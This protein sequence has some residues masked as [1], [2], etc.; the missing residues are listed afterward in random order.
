MPKQPRTNMP[1]RDCEPWLYEILRSLSENTRAA[2][3]GLASITR[4]EVPDG[5]GTPLTQDLSQYFFLPGR[6]LGQIGYG[7]KDDAGTLHLSSTFATA[8]GKIHLGYP[9]KYFTFDEAQ[10]L[11]GINKTSPAATFHVVGSLFGSGSSTL[12]AASIITAGWGTERSGAGG[13]GTGFDSLHALTQAGEPDDITTYVASN[14]SDGV[15]VGTNPHKM[16]LTGTIVPGAT[17][18]VTTRFA[19]FSANSAT[20]GFF[21]VS[22]VDSAGN[23][24]LQTV[25]P[26]LSASELS[27]TAQVWANVVRTVTCSGTPNSTGNTPNAVWF[28]AALTN[29]AHTVGFYSCVSYISV[30]QA[31]SDILRWD[32][33]SGTQSGRIDIAGRM[34]VGTGSASLDSELT[35]IPDAAATVGLKI[36]AAASQTGDLRQNVSSAG[37]TLS[38]VT[39]AGN[40]YLV[41]GAAA[42][43]VLVSDAS[44][45][46]SWQSLVS[47]E[48]EM[49]FYEDSPVYI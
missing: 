25:A 6:H 45:V 47:Y 14:T 18:T 32:V 19:P 1:P 9:N 7:D 36:K 17:Y 4:G 49:L 35:V 22:L 40:P 15:P 21:Q 30:T 44:G 39:A 24:W 8:K 3:Q 27:Q 16:G 43:A 48:D 11:V 23:E 26:T 10:A 41:A 13:D 5:S 31:G 42:D 28:S 12:I 37:V 34:G 20:D 33:S 2:S 29:V 38:G 46:G